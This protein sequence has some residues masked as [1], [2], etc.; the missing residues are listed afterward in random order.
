[1]GDRITNLMFFLSA[2]SVLLAVPYSVRADIIYV[3]ATATGANNGSSWTDAYT[4]LQDAFGAAFSGDS[5]WVASGTYKPTAGIDRTA[6]FFLI[7][8]VAVYGGFT[9]TEAMLGERD[10]DINVTILSGDIGIP[11]DSTDNSYHVVTGSGTNSTAVLDGFWIMQGRAD[12]T[13]PNHYG[14]GMLN[15]TGSPAISNITFTR[16]SSVY[17]GGLFNIFSSNPM[18][19]NVSFIGNSSRYGAGMY[20]RTSSNPTLTNVVFTGNSAANG[21]GG[22]YSSSSDPVLINVTISGN[23]ASIYG[24]GVL[25]ENSSPTLT[26]VIISDNSSGFGGG[27]N[28]RNGGSPL[29]VNVTLSG[30]SASDGGGMYNDTS[31]PVLVNTT[32]SDNSANDGGGIYNRTNS[33]PSLTNLILWNNTASNVGDEIFNSSSTPVISYSLIEGSGGS[34]GGWDPTLGTDGGNNIDANPWFHDEA[35][36][37]LRIWSSS[38]AVDAGDSTAVPVGVT[39]DLDG[40]ARIFAGQVDMG[41]YEV[42]NWP[43]GI[44]DKPEPA[45][46]EAALLRSVFPNPFN[47]RTTI[48]YSNA[49]T[50]TVSLRIFDVRGRLIQTLVEDTKTAGEHTVTWDARSVTY[51]PV[52]SGVY[53]VRLEAGGQVKTRKI[54]L[55]K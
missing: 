17:G 32:V 52:A 1:M 49:K 48:T 33:N 14:G 3:K 44:F 38:P 11:A 8:G 12:G 20:T 27:I 37:D 22:L 21:G 9:G 40:N 4:D 34:G 54:V 55:I 28:S 39:T 24:G 2:V 50:G 43:T 25:C 47:P 36:G 35:V 7:N 6:T 30:N 5:I 15:F 10:W 16:N 26:N 13:Y 29:L 42:Q 41:A 23:S 53:F 18:L 31:S 46:A 45:L 51:T 19:T